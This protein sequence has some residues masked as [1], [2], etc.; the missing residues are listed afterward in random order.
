MS[1]RGERTG[2]G[3]PQDGQAEDAGKPRTLRVSGMMLSL[4]AESVEDLAKSGMQQTQDPDDTGN[5][6]NLGK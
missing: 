4:D 1:S 6:G 5:A 3:M 2:L